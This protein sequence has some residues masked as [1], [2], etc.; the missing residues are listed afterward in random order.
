VGASDFSLEDNDDRTIDTVICG[1]NIP[2]PGDLD[3]PNVPPTD[4][5]QTGAGDL[6][7]A[8][9]EEIIAVVVCPSGTCSGVPEVTG[10]GGGASG[11]AAVAAKGKRKGSNVL[12]RGK[13]KVKFKGGQAGFVYVQMDRK[14]VKKALRKRNSIPAKLQL[15][16]GGGKGKAKKSA[17]ARKV[18][19]KLKK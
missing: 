15:A 19:F 16:S 10:P 9:C 12:G 17:S 13:R 8:D 7:G 14:K 2:A 5:A 6:V 1:G 4:S 11:S 3:N 18:R